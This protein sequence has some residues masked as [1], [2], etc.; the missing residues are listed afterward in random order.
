MSTSNSSKSHKRS[1]TKELE[2]LWEQGEIG[3]GSI[4]PSFIDTLTPRELG[5]VGEL[6]AMSYLE[7]RGYTVLEHHYRCPDGEADLIVLDETDGYIVLVEV[8][9]R[10]ASSGDNDGLC[11]EEAVDARKQKR[12]KRIAQYYAYDQSPIYALRF[13]V[14]SIVVRCGC[15]AELIHLHDAFDWEV[16]R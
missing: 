6:L 4:D 7:E 10:R 13:D 8:K 12:Y 3:P 1:R 9:T 5:E 15:V 14:I 16:E 11:P 2:E